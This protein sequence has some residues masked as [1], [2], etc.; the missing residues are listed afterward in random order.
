MNFLLIRRDLGTECTPL[1]EKRVS[2]SRGTNTQIDHNRPTSRSSG[3]HH[4]VTLMLRLLPQWLQTMVIRKPWTWVPC[5]FL[6]VTVHI[7]DRE[8]YCDT[9]IVPSVFIHHSSTLNHVICHVLGCGQAVSPFHSILCT[10]KAFPGQLPSFSPLFH[11]HQG[12]FIL[13]IVVQIWTFS[14][15]GSPLYCL[16]QQNPMWTGSCVITGSVL[17]K[18]GNDNACHPWENQHQCYCVLCMM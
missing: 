15:C 1:P 4:A 8:L 13:S 2:K 16:H 17:S 18:E 9:N 7:C 12:T 5:V 6:R 3:E 14:P 10:T 11:K